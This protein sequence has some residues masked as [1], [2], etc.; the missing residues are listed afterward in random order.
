V[1]LLFKK[2]GSDLAGWLKRESLCMLCV[3]VPTMDGA[4]P[5]ATAL[6]PPRGREGGV[7]ARGQPQLCGIRLVDVL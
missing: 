2:R 3:C 7:T 4:Y 1:A 6:Q 5:Q